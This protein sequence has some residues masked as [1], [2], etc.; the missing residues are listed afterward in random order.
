MTYAGARG[1]TAEE[2]AKV[3]HLPSRG[4]EVHRAFGQ[5]I[6]DLN[7]EKTPDGKPRGYEL[8]VANA[9]WGQKGY[10]FL[11]AFLNLVKSNYGAGL[12]EVDFEKDS[13]S[14]RQAINAWVARETRHKITEIVP[15]GVL[16]GDT[17]TGPDERHLF[18]GRMVVAVQT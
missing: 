13:E 12:N 15:P 14:A 9:L 16:S 18:Q 10:G 2:M 11:P 4:E 6:K 1:E 8:S 3:L 7:A 5:L 17:P